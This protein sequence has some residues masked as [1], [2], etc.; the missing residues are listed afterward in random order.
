[1]ARNGAT[2]NGQRQTKLKTEIQTNIERRPVV[3]F[4]VRIFVRIFVC[5]S[6]SKTPLARIGPNTIEWH[7]IEKRIAVLDPLEQPKPV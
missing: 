5:R 2:T 7:Y 4:F 6:T 3:Q 1:V